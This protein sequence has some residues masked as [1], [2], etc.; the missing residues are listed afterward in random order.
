MVEGRCCHVYTDHK[1][2]IYAFQQNLDKASSR[3]VRQLDFISQITT[4]I[5]HVNGEDNVAADLLSR[6]QSLAAEPINYDDLADDQN[7]DE[8]LKDLLKGNIHHSLKFK[9]FVLPFSSK[10]LYCD[11]S[12][13]RVRPFVTKRFRQ[14]FLRSIHNLAHPGTRGTTRL[15]AERFV[16]P[17]IQRDG[18][19]YARNCLQCQRN[20]TIRHNRSLLQ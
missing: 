2:L 7:N 20:K 18:R 12:T 1:P 4:D 16:W 14:T 6:I 15:I 9:S 3:Q 5:R 13:G 10:S 8:E 17:G 19:D 11:T